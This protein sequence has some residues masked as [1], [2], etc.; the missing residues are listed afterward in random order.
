MK[1][2]R[3]KFPGAILLL[4][5]IFS[6]CIAIFISLKLA[7]T[8]GISVSG[9]TMGI[10]I[11]II[12]AVLITPATM[13]L[14][15]DLNRENQKVFEKKIRKLVASKKYEKAMK[16]LEDNS[17]FVQD[18]KPLLSLKDEIESIILQRH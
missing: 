13:I 14:R 3:I 5:A 9:N 18:S 15:K 7:P 17:R 6:C 11:G 8:I 2:N 10:L 4:W 16:L 1:R 12:A